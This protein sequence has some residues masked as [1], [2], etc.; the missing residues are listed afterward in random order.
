MPCVQLPPS[1][2]GSNNLVILTLGLQDSEPPTP[3]LERLVAVRS[4]SLQS[5]VACPSLPSQ[6]GT[7][8]PVLPQGTA[9]SLSY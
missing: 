6:T 7:G 9:E 8:K 2:Q 5:A 4:R 1:S 3:P